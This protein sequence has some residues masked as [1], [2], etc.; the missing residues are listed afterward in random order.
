MTG[1]M[2]HLLKTA[3]MS[4]FFAAFTPNIREARVEAA[5]DNEL[6]RTRPTASRRRRWKSSGTRL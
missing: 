1:G 5:L 4:M 2:N 6:Q 3:G